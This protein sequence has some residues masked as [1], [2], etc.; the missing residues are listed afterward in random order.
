M[1]AAARARRARRRLRR[2]APPGRRDGLAARR[3]RRRDARRRATGSSAGTTPPH[4]GDRGERSS[5]RTSAAQGIGDA[6]LDALEGWAADHGCTELDGAGRARTTP[7]ASPGRSGAATYEVG[8]NSR[9]VLDLTTAETPEPR[10]AAPGSRSSPG[11]SGPSSRAALWEVAREAT[12]DIPGEEESDDRHAR[13]VARARHAGRRRRPARRLRRARGRRG[14]SATRNSS[15]SRES[16][17]AHSTTSPACGARTAAAGSR[18]PEADR[19]SPGRR[20]TGYT[21][22]RPRTRC[23]TSRSAA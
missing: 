22:S 19:R 17:S 7:A 5:S 3:A 23:G 4:R 18:A 13:G 15:L 16:R 21:S 9:L 8:R 12:P 14:A 1:R 11:P 2:L 10:P 20:R 6:L